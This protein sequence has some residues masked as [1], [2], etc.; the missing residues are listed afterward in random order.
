M[1]NQISYILSADEVKDILFTAGVLKP[2]KKKMLIILIVSI[3]FI[4]LTFVPS[5]PTTY[6]II[7]ALAFANLFTYFGYKRNEKNTVRGSTTG[8]LTV[9]SAYDTYINV[10]VEAYDANWN[11]NKDDVLKI[12]ENDN[13]IIIALDDGRL[14]AIPKRVLN[15]TNKASFDTVLNYFKDKE[16]QEK[17]GE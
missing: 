10:Q 7:V 4:V 11:I 13:Q 17:I 6:S 5:A 2:F 14:M 12:F 9:L 16:T 8:E 3:I 15:D 1:E